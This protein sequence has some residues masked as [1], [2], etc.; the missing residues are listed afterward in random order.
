[1]FGIKG[2]SIEMETKGEGLDYVQRLLN[3]EFSFKKSELIDISLIFN[4]FKL[5]NNSK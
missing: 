1:M 2:S 5:K 4:F 3:S